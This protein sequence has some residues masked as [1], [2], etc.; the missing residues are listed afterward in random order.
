MSSIILYYVTVISWAVLV[1]ATEVWPRL[2]GPSL[3]K[4]IKECEAQD[5]NS[6]VS[7]QQS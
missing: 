4:N 6:E 3:I 2:W 7:N 5:W 1:E